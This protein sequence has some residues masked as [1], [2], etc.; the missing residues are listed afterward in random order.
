[1]E[2]GRFLGMRV[3]MIAN[4]GAYAHQVGPLI[5]FIGATM[6]TGVYDIQALDVS[7]LGVYTNTAPI[8]AYRGAGRPEAAFLVETLVDA[9]A[10][11]LGLTP[12]EIRRRNFIKP[13]QLP[14]RTQT[15][16]LYDTG[17]FQGHMEKAMEVAGW[18]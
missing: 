18:A 7:I 4:L 3:R 16:R 13:E 1:D 15:G 8:D 5:P 9:C 10:R 17:E 14:Y 6:S 11:D 2:N 12:D